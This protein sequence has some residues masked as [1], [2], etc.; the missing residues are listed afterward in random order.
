MNP[1]CFKVYD[2]RVICEKCGDEKR[3][4]PFRAC[5]FGHITSSHHSPEDLSFDSNEASL[6]VQR[7]GI[8]A[9]SVRS[10]GDESCDVKVEVVNGC[11]FM[12]SS[13]QDQ[14][15][16]LSSDFQPPSHH[17]LLQDSFPTQS[18]ASCR[19]VTPAT[20]V[21]PPFSPSAILSAN[22]RYKRASSPSMTRK[23][24]APAMKKAKAGTKKARVRGKEARSPSPDPVIHFV[25]APPVPVPTSSRRAQP[26]PST[27]TP[28]PTTTL[29]PPSSSALR[30]KTN[31]HAKAKVKSKWRG[32]VYLDENEIAP[33]GLL[34]QDVVL[35]GAQT[36]T[37][38]SRSYAKQIV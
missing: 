29:S 4:D 32:W 14:L 5:P 6:G 1:H 11:E 3:V 31:V 24:P 34:E 13:T 7:R 37:L 15:P 17:V 18:A 10:G 19:V 33:R 26:P 30:D 20:I 35:G 28:A 9:S 12:T 25:M 22:A 23:T 36:R 16:Q 21:E 2:G 27:I 8:G 38:R